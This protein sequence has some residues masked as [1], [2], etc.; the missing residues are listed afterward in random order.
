MRSGRILLRRVRPSDLTDFQAYRNDPEVARYQGWEMFSDS[1]AEV[2][3]TDAGTGPL[4]LPG[5]W[6]QIGIALASS[7]RLI[8][9]IG[10]RLEEDETELEIG[11][12]LG[13]PSQGQGLAS[14]ALAAAIK[15]VLEQTPAD[16]II[17]IADARN[18]PSIRLLE[19]AGM[20]RV[21]EQEVVF[22]GEPCVEF[23]YAI[24]RNSVAS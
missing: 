7:E 11:I 15:L 13:R 18:G 2:F 1:E 19:R 16:R 8:G 24:S 3:L 14:E 20:L 22:R 23:V 12:S 5:R 6:C 17:G 4:L 10:L 9:D 21:A